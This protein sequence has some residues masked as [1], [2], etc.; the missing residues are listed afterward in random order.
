LIESQR[1][2]IGGVIFGVGVEEASVGLSLEAERDEL[3][4][5]MCREGL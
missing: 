1:K 5:D 3:E 2:D 4:R